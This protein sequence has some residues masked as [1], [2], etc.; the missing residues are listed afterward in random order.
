MSRKLKNSVGIISDTNVLIVALLFLY[1]GAL[2]VI[3]IFSQIH[4]FFIG[5]K[6]TLRF[7]SYTLIWLNILIGMMVHSIALAQDNNAIRLATQD[8]PPYQMISNGELT[9]LA[10]ERV[11]CALDQ[12]DVHY[13]ILLTNWS[14]AQLL[15]QKG[16]VAGFFVGSKNSA[17]EVYATASM[18]VIENTLAWYMLKNSLVNPANP[19]DKIK[20]RYS[21]KFATSKWLELKRSNFNVVKKPKNAEVLLDMLLTGDID[22]ALEY[23]AVFDHLIRERGLDKKS[24]RIVPIRSKE[25][26]VHFS[27]LFLSARPQ[28]LNRFNASLKNC[29]EAEN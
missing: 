5:R 23:E 20:A 6:Y 7:K 25:N 4:K 28:F 21:A 12:M 11:K 10:I 9:G 27:N 16:E 14:K 29:L 3:L 15:T 22:V 18:A 19:A 17:R 2:R 26:M 1:K 24:F 8:W 13:E